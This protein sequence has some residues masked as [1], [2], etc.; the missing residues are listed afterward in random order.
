MK[1]I[2]HYDIVA[3]AIIAIILIVY[4]A[5]NH[6]KTFSNKVYAVLLWVS[7][8]STIT[9][10]AA[11]FAGSFYNPKNH[12]FFIIVN[13]IHFVV[14]NLVPCI[15]CLF[16]YAIVYE[17]S[18]L[19]KKWFCIIFVPYMINFLLI[20]STP[21]TNACFYYDSLGVYHRGNGQFFTYTIAIYYV[22][23]SC[24]IVLHNIKKLSKTQ[25]L[26]VIFYTAESIILNL[27]QLFFSQF[28]LQ[29]IGIAFAMF[30][31]Y[32]TLQNPLEYMDLQTGTFNRN[33]FKKTIESKLSQK[34][35]FSIVC[36]QVEGLTYI[37]EKFG[38][39]NGNYLLKE[40]SSFLHSLNKKNDIFRI[41]NR[42]FVLL[43][44]AKIQSENYPLQIIEK[45]KKPFYF[46]DIN[47]FSY[48]WAYICY[49]ENSKNIHSVSDFFTIVDT[50]FSEY[51]SKNKNKIIYASSDILDKRRRENIIHQAI[52]NAIE[53]RTFQVYFQ[54]IYSTVDNCYTNMEALVRLIDD[55]HGFIPPDEFIPIAEKNGDIIAIGE[56]VL[57]K[58]CEF[59]ELYHPQ[60]Y[61]IKRIHVNLSVVQ[62]MQE[63]ITASLSS[64]IKRHNIP[65]GF[66]D[67][68]IT[69]TT[70]DNTNDRLEKIM[71]IF[72]EQGIDFSLDDYGTGYSNQ[73]NIMKY[74]YSIVKID[75]SMVWACDTNPKALISLKHTISM[76]RELNMTVLAEGVET[77]KQR[78]FLKNIGCEYLQGFYFSKPQPKDDVID[79]IKHNKIIGELVNA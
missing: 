77:E 15:Y 58:V 18:K 52:T 55:N 46:S 27:I 28:L 37:N 68:E 11:A 50:S 51:K 45:F 59:T 63:N 34:I 1:W 32:I 71:N 22:I 79:I 25:S 17:N 48:L 53:N 64:I 69:E 57:E 5:F 20:I 14:Q 24:F 31:I 35:D 41:S 40:I 42:Q 70:A 33:L 8:L 21:F 12:A 10:I 56:I 36:I 72:K 76:I 44:P 78:I 73:T 7:L 26:S 38:I 2:I 30:F 6:I 29:E 54:P 49:F 23:T 39:S 75:K 4:S 3:L 65:F 13:L 67:F 16:A 47:V 61:G 74:P 19:N 9:D 43:C 62:C 60:D 66:I